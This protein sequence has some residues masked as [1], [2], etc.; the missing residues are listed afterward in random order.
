MTPRGK[1]LAGRKENAP[2]PSKPAR[3]QFHPAVKKKTAAEVAEEEEAAQAAALLQEMRGTPRPSK[4][5]RRCT[6]RSRTP[7]GCRQSCC[8]TATRPTPR[9]ARRPTWG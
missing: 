9:A 1:E 7:S 3:S 6:T 4:Q 2:Q 8:S 5:K